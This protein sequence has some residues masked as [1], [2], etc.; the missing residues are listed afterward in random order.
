M[1][2]DLLNRVLDGLDYQE[3]EA[4]PVEFH[5]GCDDGRAARAILALGEDEL[6]DM[7]EKGETAEVRCHFCGK[8]HHLSP[9]QLRELRAGKRS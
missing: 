9:D 3:L 6:D 4:M 8:V 7:I 2:N 5:C 1:P